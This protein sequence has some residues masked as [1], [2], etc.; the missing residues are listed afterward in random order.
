M[1]GPGKSP[2]VIVALASLLAAGETQWTGGGGQRA[3]MRPESARHVGRIQDVSSQASSLSTDQVRVLVRIPGHQSGKRPW[4]F[5]APIWNRN[6]P[7]T[8]SNKP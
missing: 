2:V 4:R 7:L 6:P 1:A 5:Q 3:L 8:V